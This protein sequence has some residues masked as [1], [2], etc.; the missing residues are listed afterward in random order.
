MSGIY[1][2]TRTEILEGY[3]GAALFLESD[4]ETETSLADTYATRDF[5][6]EARDA[7][8]A[9]VESFLAS[10]SPADFRL[11]AEQLGAS[12]FGSDLWYDRPGSG[13][14]LFDEHLGEAGD[15]LSAVA[16]G[17]GTAH[18]FPDGHGKVYFA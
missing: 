12:R 16:R 2:I 17:L 8:V 18:V 3:L 7:A 6:P 5:T 1:D 14:G 15:R 4:P 10:S 9:D 11:A 13:V